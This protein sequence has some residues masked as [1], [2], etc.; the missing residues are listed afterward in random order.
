MNQGNS[1]T[2]QNNIGQSCSYNIYNSSGTVASSDY[3]DWYLSGGSSVQDGS[4]SITGNPMLTS[5]YMPQSGSP[6]LG[7]ATNLTKLGVSSLDLDMNNAARPGNGAWD[8]GVYEVGA[9]GSVA[10]PSGLVATVQ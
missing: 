10:A 8:T 2:V 1:L 3:N 4:H 7:A 9:A 6:V 5:N